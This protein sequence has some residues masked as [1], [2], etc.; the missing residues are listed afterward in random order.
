MKLS[1]VAVLIAALF[2]NQAFAALTGSITLQG[3]VAATTSITVTAQA[4]Y[5]SLNLHAT[6]SNLLV[7]TVNEQNNTAAGYTVTL[8]SNNSG[9]LKNGALGEVTYTARYNGSSVSLSSSPV[10]ITTQGA[11]SAV[12]DLNKNLDVSYTGIPAA[13]LMAGTYSDT[14]TFTIASN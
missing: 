10:T 14:L 8:A 9:K 11:Q 4:G 6:Q 1:T 5:N 12:V 3:S 13:Q 2:T 7:A